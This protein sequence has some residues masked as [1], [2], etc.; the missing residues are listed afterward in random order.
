M[1]SRLWVRGMEL[2]RCMALLVVS[3]HFR[4]TYVR[5]SALCAY[6]CCARAIFELCTPY[7]PR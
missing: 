2:C 7:L 1:C 3:I 6:A 5:A 4:C